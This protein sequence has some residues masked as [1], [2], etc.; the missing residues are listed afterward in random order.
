MHSCWVC[1]SCK[2]CIIIHEP[3]WP[4]REPANQLK[5]I[6]LCKRHQIGK[7]ALDFRE[8]QWCVQSN[9]R[10]VWASRPSE[11][12]PPFNPGPTMVPNTMALNGP[13]P[14]I[15]K[16][17]LHISSP[18][19]QQILRYPRSI[20]PSSAPQTLS[21]SCPL[22]L[23]LPWILIIWQNDSLQSVIQLVSAPHVVF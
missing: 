5:T 19:F 21:L 23:F 9:N 7:F 20:S 12:G 3:M 17:Y 10:H 22:F 6:C 4:Q 13:N 14:K 16:L 18:N 15:K 8:R 2:T 11:S 1:W